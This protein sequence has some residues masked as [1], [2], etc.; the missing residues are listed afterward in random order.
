MKFTVNKNRKKHKA[1]THTHR[2]TQTHN[3]ILI[4]I[5]SSTTRKLALPKM[6][7]TNE[8]EIIIIII[9]NNDCYSVS[10]IVLKPSV[11]FKQAQN[12]P[13]MA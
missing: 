13:N 2:N 4:Y 9:I 5:V 1:H 7:E 8:I 11:L 10:A 6:N 3:E 12:V